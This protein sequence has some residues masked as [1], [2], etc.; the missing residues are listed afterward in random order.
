[1]KN[2]AFGFY[3]AGLTAILAIATL[4]IALVYR[5]QGGTVDVLAI[6][7]LAGAIV[8]E[9][10]LLS[11]EHAWSDYVSIIPA[12]LLAYAMMS[13]L[14]DGIWN[15]AEAVNGIKM[16]GKPELMSLNVTMAI[17][18]LIAIITAVVTSFAS[19]SKQAA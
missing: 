18:N 19:K 17:V 7:A 8:C 4:V 10:A 11:G 16:V 1:M 3:S 12:A 14:Q 2:K 6:A 13:I 9:A 5:S 15:I